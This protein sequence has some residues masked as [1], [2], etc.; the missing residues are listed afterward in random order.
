MVEQYLTA[1]GEVEAGRKALNGMHPL[2]HSGEPN[3][4]GYGGV[5]LPSDE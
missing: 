5:Y 4:I 2:G 1:T 3:D